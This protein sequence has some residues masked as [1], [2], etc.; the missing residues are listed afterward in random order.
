MVDAGLDSSA[1]VKYYGSMAGVAYSSTRYDSLQ[2]ALRD[3]DA[4]VLTHEHFDHANGV[5]RG[6]YFKASRRQDPS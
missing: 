6:S 4:I 5:Q 2:L 1:I 3:A